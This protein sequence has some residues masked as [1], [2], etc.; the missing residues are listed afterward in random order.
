MDS[1][2]NS[3]QRNRGALMR[4]DQTSSEGVPMSSSGERKPCMIPGYREHP[5]EVGGDRCP[6]SRG[7]IEGFAGY[8]F[9]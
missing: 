9:A 5:G 8:P 7:F 3:V 1:S 4:G 2:G 6:Q